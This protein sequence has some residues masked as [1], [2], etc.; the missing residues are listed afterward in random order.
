MATRRAAWFFV[1][2][3][4]VAARVLGDEES[5]EAA[6]LAL[7]QRGLHEIPTCA[8]NEVCGADLQRLA[9]YARALPV[10]RHRGGGE[11]REATAEVDLEAL[12]ARLGPEFAAALAVNEAEHA[13][14]C[15]KSCSSFYCAE[16]GNSFEEARLV[17]TREI[18]MGSVPPEDFASAFHYPLDLIRV[19]QEPVVTA[20]DAKRVIEVAR[21]ENVDGN[22]FTSGKYKLGGDWLVNLDETRRWFN[23]LLKTSIY[24]NIA[25]SFPEVVTNASTLR[26]HSVALLKY[27]KTHPRTD[28]HIDNGI[29]ALTLALSPRRDYEGGGTF[30]EHLGEKALVEMDVGMATWR[31]GS[32]R[33]GGHRVTAGERYILGAFFLL[34]DRVEHVRRLKNRGSKLRGQGDLEN[35]ARHFSWA[36]EINPQCTTCLKDLAEL[37]MSNASLAEAE[38]YLRQAL[39]LL[40]RDSDALY[41]LG[42]V[43]SQRGDDRSALEAYESSADVNPDDAELLYN[44]GLKLQQVQGA[45]D[46]ERNMYKRALAVDPGFSKARCNLGV[47]LAEAGDGDAAEAHLLEAATDPTVALTALQNLA[48]LYE[49]RAR[50]ALASFPTASS[51]DQAI[52]I[53]GRADVP[54]A[55]A[56]AAWDKLTADASVSQVASSRLLNVLKTRA[57]LVAISDVNAAIPLLRRATD[58]APT[59]AFAWQALAKAADLVAD[60]ATATKARAALARLAK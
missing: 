26:A 46:D 50:L 57:R 19:T 28:V 32:V 17:R 60:H 29:V 13:R 7:W 31:P 43:L 53:A 30:F 56:Q 16:P 37:H 14:D 54:L 39:D 48:V 1:L 40:P 15:D 27:N 8:E 22:V 20:S 34:S 33:H 12:K 6:R 21:R 23:D 24:P 3:A 10:L 49:E 2:A 35:A 42:V 45:G 44:L 59:D 47:S 18:S 52:A 55:K 25:A 41:S 58:L 4:C 11:V 38:R 5:L 9:S 36:L 51:K